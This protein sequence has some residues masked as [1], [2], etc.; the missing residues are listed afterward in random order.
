[1][2]LRPE[3]DLL[4]WELLRFIERICKQRGSVTEGG[5]DHHRIFVEMNN[6]GMRAVVKAI[7]S[8]FRLATSR[9]VTINGLEGISFSMTTT[10]QHFSCQ[11][12]APRVLK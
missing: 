4:N 10:Y 9:A 11:L 5:P 3:S 8:G 6:R 12:E 2:H 1:M 7:I